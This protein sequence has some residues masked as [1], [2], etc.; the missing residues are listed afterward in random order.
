MADLKT[1]YKDDV[2]D[3]S[4]N[5]RRKFNMITNPDG[6]VSFEDVTEYT[7]VGD[8]FCGEDM[9]ATNQAITELND[10][11]SSTIHY[12]C[13]IECAYINSNSSSIDIYKKSGL[14]VIN[15]SINFNNQFTELEPWQ[16]VIIGNVSN[17]EFG[18][19]NIHISSINIS[20]PLIRI[21]INNNGVVSIANADYAV[22]VGNKWFYGNRVIVA[23]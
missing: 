21:I 3:T 20:T 18:N 23:H 8:S 10:A 5:T 4:V 12:D 9:N 22:S 6:T 13:I 2:L 15:A 11:L 17:W 14:V 1:N 7:Q 16:E 19:I